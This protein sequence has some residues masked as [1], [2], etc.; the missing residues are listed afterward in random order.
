MS[1]KCNLPDGK[2]NID[3][4][5]EQRPLHYQT[6]L[7]CSCDEINKSPQIIRF[8]ETKDSDKTAIPKAPTPSET[9]DLD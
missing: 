4:Q 3:L 6:K 7:L 1:L 9:K 8:T 5:A 2:K